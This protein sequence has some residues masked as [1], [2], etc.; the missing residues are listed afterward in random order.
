LKIYKQPLLSIDCEYKKIIESFARRD[1]IL[2]IC[3]YIAI[4]VI[5]YFGIR[6]L[7]LAPLARGIADIAISAMM[8][9]VTFIL[10]YMQKQKLHTLGIAKRN[11]L[12]SS[13]VG[14]VIGTSLFLF[15]RIVSPGALFP[16]EILSLSFV[17]FALYHFILIGFT[18]EL[19]FR[20]FIQTRL[21]GIIKSDNWA[22]FITG[23][24]FVALHVIADR[25]FIAFVPGFEMARY[26]VF[27]IVLTFIAHIGLNALY[28]KYNSL[29][30]PVILHGLANI[31][32][33]QF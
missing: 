6:F 24:L 19:I 23:F 7:H 1:G 33:M 22:I 32:S 17:Y 3:L 20:G 11:C 15:V 2:A 18:E 13:V 14:L 27:N 4:V 21:Y 5:I 25:F 29:L 9:I 12:K 30:G 28:R 8:I 10:L 16:S 26:S 31:S